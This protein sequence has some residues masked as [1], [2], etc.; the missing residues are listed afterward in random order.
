MITDANGGKR[1]R[2]PGRPDPVQRHYS[3]YRCGFPARL[4]AGRASAVQSPCRRPAP[5]SVSNHALF[6]RS[7]MRAINFITLACWSS[8]AASTGSWSG[9]LDFDLVAALFGDMTPSVADRLRPGRLVGSLPADALSS[10]RSARAKR[11]PSAPRTFELAS[12][13]ATM[14]SRASP[15][16]KT[17]LD[18]A[19]LDRRRFGRRPGL[20]EAREKSACRRR[21]AASEFATRRAK[22]P[23]PARRRSEAGRARIPCRPD[24][25]A[26]AG[27][28]RV[29]ARR[30]RRAAC[31]PCSTA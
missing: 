19:V 1:D 12:A 2:D 8:S 11:A 3:C 22:L 7:K 4:T 24:R 15:F 23:W 13:S 30:C 31:A 28:A 27:S 10:N 18:P 9:L 5:A 29:P 25:R 6:R 16:G 14:R 17:R 21:S 20:R 26:L